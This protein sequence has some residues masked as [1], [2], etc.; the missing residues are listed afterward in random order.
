[1]KKI[2]IIVALMFS[3]N[4]FAGILLEPYVGYHIAKSKQSGSPSSDITGAG[5]GARI[6]WTLPLVFVA[7]DYSGGSLTEKNSGGTSEDFTYTAMG[8]VVGASLPLLRLWAGYNFSSTAKFKTSG[9]LEGDGMKA[10]VGFKMPVLPIS[11]NVEYTIDTYDK[12]NGSSF[13]PEEKQSGVFLS[14]SAPLT[15]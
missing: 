3:V 9:K 12:L 5:Y 13:T 1:M 2:L 14:V 6:G 4:S 10:G 7:F 11:F 8:A 15:F